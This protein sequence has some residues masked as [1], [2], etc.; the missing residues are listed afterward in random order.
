MAASFQAPSQGYVVYIC[1][2][3]RFET[4]PPFLS[5]GID[6]SSHIFQRIQIKY[7]D[8]YDDEGIKKYFAAFHLLHPFPRPVIIDDFGD[9]F[10]ESKCQQRYNN[11]RGRDLALV[12]VLALC[13]SAIIHANKTAAC[14]LLLSDTHH[15]ESPRL[16]IYK[17]WLS[18]I[19]TIQGEGDGSGSFLLK[20]S[21][22]MA[23]NGIG[24]RSARYSIAL[25]YL[26]LEG[27][28]EDAQI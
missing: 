10:L 6:A 16:F 27:I 25:Q 5:Q 28:I 1:N 3:R 23:G 17:R 9:F 7:V 13:H 4:K 26:V 19:F 15:G 20:H 8:D 11:S 24:K 2:R 14:Q 21:M 22:H 12:R 18:S